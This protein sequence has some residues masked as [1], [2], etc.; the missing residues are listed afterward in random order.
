MVEIFHVEMKL[1]F[2]KKIAI[3]PNSGLH[4][5]TTVTAVTAVSNLHSIVEYASTQ[6][7]GAHFCQFDNRQYCPFMEKMRSNNPV[8]MNFVTGPRAPVLGKLSIYHVRTFGRTDCFSSNSFCIE[9]D[10]YFNIT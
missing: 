9:S 6:L 8:D 5:V 1:L 7:S 3:Q 4:V 10:I 2:E